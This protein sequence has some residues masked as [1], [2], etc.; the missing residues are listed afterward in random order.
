VVH[1]TDEQLAQGMAG[2]GV[3]APY[4]PTF[5]SFD[6]NT[7]E[8][9]IAMVTTDA[10]TLSGAQPMSLESFLEASKAALLG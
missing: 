1:L 2:A 10:A 8:G 5:V 7:R 6:A 4:I 9:K 3:P